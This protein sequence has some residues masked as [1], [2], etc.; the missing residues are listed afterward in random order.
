MST[1]SRRTREA[2]QTSAARTA[3]IRRALLG[4]YD[5]QARDLPWRR[6]SDPYRVWLSEVMLQ[7]TRVETVVPY[8]ERWL[9]R[10]P[11]LGAVAEAS[12]EEILSSWAGLGYYRRARAFHEA[13]G[14]VRDR[15]AGR[16]PEDPDA[17]RELPG[18]GRYTAA[19]IAS[20]AFGREALAVDTNTRR[21]LSR[22][23]D[24]ARSTTAA[25]ERVG[26]PLVAGARPGDTNQALMELG[27]TVCLPRAPRCDRCPVAR[28]CLARARGTTT[29][30][31]AA[32]A[33][34]RVAA[35]RVG[36]AVLVAGGRVLVARRPRDGMLGGMW[37]LPGAISGRGESPA[38]AAARVRRALVG[39]R[40]RGRL[41]AVVDHVYT[42]RRHTYHAYRFDAGHGRVPDTAPRVAGAARWDAIDWRAIDELSAL[43]MGSA[44]RRLVRALGETC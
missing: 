29:T 24:L 21:V 32:S 27:A 9:E 23:F 17:L 40:G 15:H 2:S 33:R 35:Y 12:L 41:V 28:S 34:R 8:Y 6:E 44:Q 7:Q 26:A 39:G 22:L 18:V 37:E 5:L 20:I 38:G 25:L 11:T 14:V 42:H 16:T 1:K 4:W 19:A 3:A 36:S 10:F 31:P 43:A 30:R 13:A